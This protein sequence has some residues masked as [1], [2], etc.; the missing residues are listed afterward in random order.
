L[1]PADEFVVRANLNRGGAFHGQDDLLHRLCQ[2]P[3]LVEGHDVFKMHVALRILAASLLKVF[4]SIEIR[5]PEVELDLPTDGFQDVLILVYEE[6]FCPL[7][8]VDLCSLSWL[9]FRFGRY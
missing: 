5:F 8:L 9:V 1:P 3:H 2:F 4:V 7:L 6:V